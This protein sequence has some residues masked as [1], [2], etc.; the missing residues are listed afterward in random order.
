[1]IHMNNS[2]TG[3]LI[4]ALEVVFGLIGLIF[5]WINSAEAL[6]IL[7]LGLSTF[8]IHQQNVAIGRAQGVK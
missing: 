7:T 1:M 2:T 3:Y 6:T 4:A 8:G 5:G